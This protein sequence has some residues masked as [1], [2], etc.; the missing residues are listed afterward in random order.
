MDTHDQHSDKQLAE[1][2]QVLR[3]LVLDTAAGDELR[4]Y[5]K[6]A[7][8]Q[9]LELYGVEAGA[10]TLFDEEGNSAWTTAAGDSDCIDHL[11]GI[12]KAFLQS[13]RSVHHVRSLFMTI[14][15][16]GPAGVFSYPLKSGGVIYG[17][18]SG[19]ARG[20]RNLTQEEE[21]IAV[22]AA[23]MAVAA[24][25]QS[26]MRPE[27]LEKEVLAQTRSDAIAELI[28]AINHQ[29]N[30]PLTAITGNLQLLLTKANQLPD[31][32]VRLLRKID[33]GA[34]RIL[35]VIRKL[36]DLKE[37]KSTTYI[38]GT[39]MIDLDNIDPPSEEET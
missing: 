26:R 1:R 9:S 25:R 24:E 18:I 15:Q 19:L 30:N 14:D 13:L 5:L 36:R 3:Q 31:D 23:M 37:A 10:I 8:Q 38:N 35:E 2:Y 16:D 12:E 20:D 28:V 29:I 34:E 27:S 11:A 17:A 6:R 32:V 7:L 33:D 21:F 22:T 39:M 4:E